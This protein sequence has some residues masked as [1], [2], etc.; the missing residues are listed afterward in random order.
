MKY[1]LV[2]I[3]WA[4]AV[5]NNIRWFG[6]DEAKDWAK[7]INFVVKECGFVM[8]ETSKYTFLVNRLSNTEYHGE[9]DKECGGLHKIPKT[10]IRKRKVLKV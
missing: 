6:E 7:N 8:K 5:S 2:Y 1:K 10:W 9:G 3:E 4:D